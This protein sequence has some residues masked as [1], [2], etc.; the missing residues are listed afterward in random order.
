MK[1]RQLFTISGGEHRRLANHFRATG[2]FVIIHEH[3]QD[4]GCDGSCLMLNL[5]D[6]VRAELSDEV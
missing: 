5:P 1:P 6:E 3:R 2:E 4:F